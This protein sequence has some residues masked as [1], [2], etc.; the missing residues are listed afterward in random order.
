LTPAARRSSLK[1][2]TRTGEASPRNTSGRS[3]G[4]MTR[5]LRATSLSARP[6]RMLQ[7]DLYQLFG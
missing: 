3:S 7:M 4:S 5:K 6:I 1:M 2:R